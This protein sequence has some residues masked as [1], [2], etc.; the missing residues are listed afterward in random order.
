MDESFICECGEHTRFAYFGVFV[1][2][3]SC[4]NEYKFVSK[5]DS[6]KNEH[7]MRR[8]NGDGNYYPK[9]W[10]QLPTTPREWNSKLK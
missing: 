1:R 2:C 9:N 5:R 6:S 8:F 4:Y 3:M 10:E 7:W